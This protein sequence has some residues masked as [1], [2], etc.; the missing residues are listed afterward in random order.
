MY[1][2]HIGDTDPF[3]FLF[4]LGFEAEIRGEC[5]ALF[6]DLWVREVPYFVVV[7]LYIY[8]SCVRSTGTQCFFRVKTKG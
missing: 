5:F 8:A 7:C 4:L 2:R 6:G 3:F 1:S